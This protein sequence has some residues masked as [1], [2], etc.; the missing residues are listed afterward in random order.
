[1]ETITLAIR[2]MTCMGC[3]SGVRQV[4]GAM[5]GVSGAEVTLQPAQATIDYDPARVSPESIR[6]A[7]IEAGYEPA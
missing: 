4:L 6:H 5:P 1:M 7:L 2:G 3:V